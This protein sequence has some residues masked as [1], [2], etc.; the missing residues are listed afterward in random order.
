MHFLST[1]SYGFI[2]LACIISQN[3]KQNKHRGNIMQRILKMCFSLALILCFSLSLGACQKKSSRQSDSTSKVMIQD[4]SYSSLTDA[5]NGAKNGDTIKI[6]DD[7]EDKNVVITKPLSIQGVIDQG[8]I[9]P[10]FYGSITIDARGINDNVEIENIEIIH[11][12]KN[13]N[14]ENNNTLIGISLLDGGL[15]LKSSKIALE[16]SNK[17]ESGAMG[18]MI[19][20]R[21]DSQNLMPIIIKG[22]DFGTYKLS[23][24]KLSGAMVIQSDKDNVFDKIDVDHELFYQ[25][26]TFDFSDEGNQFVSIK[27][28]KTPSQINYLVTSSSKELVEKLMENQSNEYNTYILKNATSSSEKQTDPIYIFPKTNLSLEGNKQIDFGGNIFKVQGTVNID[29]E[30][31][32]ATFEKISSTANIMLGDEISSENITIK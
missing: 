30:T 28:T 29:A 16:D 15:N 4:V 25:Q 14:G 23:D 1:N 18:I 8:H 26:N 27:Y 10:K 19:S 22:N 2:N 17:A 20:R 32:N 13:E 24:S 7:V 5:V 6:Y 31:Q 9:K 12:G 21:A 3:F 11:K